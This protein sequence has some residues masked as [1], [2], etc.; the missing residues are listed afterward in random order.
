MNK[1]KKRPNKAAPGGAQCPAVA[2]A[3]PGQA[4]V[5]NAPSQAVVA[6]APGQAAEACATTPITTEK[7]SRT[8]SE[9]SRKMEEMT[10]K[11]SKV[12]M[13]AMFDITD[14]GSESDTS[15]LVK[16]MREERSSVEP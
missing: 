8:S 3:A 13:R 9:E 5:A 15:N 2:E 10:K 14:S 11:S 16:E 7:G 12:E 1:K 4:A 6:N